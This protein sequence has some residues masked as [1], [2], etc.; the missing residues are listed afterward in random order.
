MLIRMKS[1]RQKDR[2]SKVK[3]DFAFSPLH[4]NET[5]VI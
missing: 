3:L 5:D 1:Q 4:L 2:E